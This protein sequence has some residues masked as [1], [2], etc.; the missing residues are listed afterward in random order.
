MAEEAWYYQSKTIE[1]RDEGNTQKYLNG[2]SDHEYHLHLKLK[3]QGA[4]LSGVF[5]EKTHRTMNG[6]QKLT[7]W[8]FSIYKAEHE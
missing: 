7:Y 4:A 5:Y 3:V 1:N 2:S 8:D 6:D